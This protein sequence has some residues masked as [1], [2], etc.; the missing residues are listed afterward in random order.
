MKYPIDVAMSGAV[1][2][3]PS[4]VCDGF[5]RD[6]KVRVQTH[7]HVDH[8]N[9]FES[10]KGYQEILLSRATKELLCIERNADL[11]Y[12]SNLRVVDE[13]SHYELDG[14]AMISLKSSGH[15]LGAVQV[16]VCFQ[17]G[18]TLGYSGDFS[19]PIDTAI[20]VEALVLD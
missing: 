6:R 3:G 14:S 11:P 15:M 17:D 13:S 1:C 16:A 12:R 18:M 7:V 4:I 5:L 10:S 19:W 9:D 20:E 8:M 2:L